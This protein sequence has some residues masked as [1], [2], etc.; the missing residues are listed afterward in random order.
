M[1]RARK[2]TTLAIYAA[3]FA[4]F[5]SVPSG[6]ELCRMDFEEK[7]YDSDGTRIT[8]TVKVVD[9]DQLPLPLVARL[10]KGTEEGLRTNRGTTKFKQD[11]MSGSVWV[12]YDYEAP[13]TGPVWRCTVELDEDVATDYD[14]RRSFTPCYDA[15][16]DSTWNIYSAGVY[17]LRDE[18][19]A[20][21]FKEAMEAL[22]GEVTLVQE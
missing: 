2:D 8:I 20:T 13:Y 22:G 17:Y 18:A 1:S 7:P 11:A 4:V 12:Q 9:I 5:D 19:R 3:A 10:Q 21:A 16:G 15:D 14:Q 6:C